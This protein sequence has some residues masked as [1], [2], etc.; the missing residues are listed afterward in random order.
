MIKTSQLLYPVSTLLHSN[1]LIFWN[2][3][4]FLPAKLWLL[5]PSSHAEKLVRACVASR[6]GCCNVPL[7]GSSVGPV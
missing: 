3:F 2:R 7:S 5:L 4:F 1:K 6:P